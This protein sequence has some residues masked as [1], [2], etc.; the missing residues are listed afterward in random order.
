MGNLSN[1]FVSGAA[2]F[3]GFHVCS[4]LIDEGFNVIGLDNNNN[5]YDT[6]LKKSRLLELDKKGNKIYGF[7]IDFSP[8]FQKRALKY[9]FSI[10][11]HPY[12]D[13]F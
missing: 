8:V 9:N 5:Y 2:G 12:C 7:A 13:L 10:L 4:R 3:I 6:K 1:I 11:G